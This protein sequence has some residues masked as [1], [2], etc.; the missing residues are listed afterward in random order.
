MA[1]NQRND[2]DIRSGAAVSD[3][4]ARRPRRPFTEPG[5]SPA[6][7]GGSL[8]PVGRGGSNRRTRPDSPPRFSPRHAKMRR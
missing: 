6:G 4:F 8:P 2:W 3:L 7:S 5:Y 1:S